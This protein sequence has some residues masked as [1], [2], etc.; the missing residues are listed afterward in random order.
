MVELTLHPVLP[1][2]GELADIKL[3]GLVLSHL[4]SVN[5]QLWSKGPTIKNK[6]LLALGPPKDAG[7]TFFGQGQIP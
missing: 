2:G 1:L 5:Y 7:H 4:V 6:T 3:Q